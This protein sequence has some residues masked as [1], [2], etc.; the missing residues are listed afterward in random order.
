MPTQP[1]PPWETRTNKPF[2]TPL[3]ADRIVDAAL[4]VL[5]RD[6]Y[7]AVSMRK[8]AQE[9]DTGA[10]SLYA[11]VANKRELDSLMVDRVARDLE[12]P[13]P[14]P[15]RWQEQIAEVMRDRL[16]VMRAYPGV[17]RAAIGNIP[18]GERSLEGSDRMLGILRAGGVPDQ[19]AAY[20]V[21]LLSLYVCAV[22]FEE[23]V[24]GAG[25]WTGEG[26]REWVDQL[27]G[28][29]RGLPADRFPNVV[30]LASALT[31]GDG[32]DRFEFG[33][34]VIVAGLTSFVPHSS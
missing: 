34:Q 14:D 20:A 9:L 2:R 29:F 15:D 5:V 21:D 6:G 19:Q 8:V 3:S 17:A 24:R 13:E 16:A 7:D 23:T 26:I 28:Y 1:R 32:D 22:A 18:L 25:E 27:T 12:I 31:A 10:A 11:H 33:V 30:A 4:K